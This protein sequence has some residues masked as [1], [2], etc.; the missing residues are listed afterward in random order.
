MTLKLK[1]KITHTK[2]LNIPLV[3]N[4]GFY[5]RGV[6]TRRVGPGG[7]GGRVRNN[8]FILQGIGRRKSQHGTKGGPG[9]STTGFK[10]RPC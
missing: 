2:R 10:V 9:K 4:N 1:K 3:G 7:G 6:I 5:G 8:K